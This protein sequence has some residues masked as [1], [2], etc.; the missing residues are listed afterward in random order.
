[1]SAHTLA[2]TQWVG[3]FRSTAEVGLV[4]IVLCP[5]HNLNMGEWDLEFGEWGEGCEVRGLGR[6]VLG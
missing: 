3:N 5:I 1:M 2:K 6:S 4:F